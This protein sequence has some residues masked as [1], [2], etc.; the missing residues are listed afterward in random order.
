MKKEVKKIS[1]FK[2]DAAVLQ[3]DLL[4]HVLGGI[5]NPT[6]PARCEEAGSKYNDTVYVKPPVIIK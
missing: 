6:D 2:N 4:S 3:S 5:E 1:D